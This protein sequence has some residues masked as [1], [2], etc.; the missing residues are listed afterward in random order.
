MCY[1]SWSIVHS[2]LLFN[3]PDP[4][5]WTLGIVRTDLH[6]LDAILSPSRH[7]RTGGIKWTVGHTRL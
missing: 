1:S 6:R 2:Y 4:Q 5:K 7:W 3:Q